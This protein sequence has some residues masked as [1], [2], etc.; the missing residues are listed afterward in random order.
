M[1]EMMN[2][3]TI[4]E[5]RT[6]I[7]PRKFVEL[8]GEEAIHQQKIR[9]AYNKSVDGIIET[10]RLMAIAKKE[11]DQAAW[12]RLQSSLP[13]TLQTIR[14]MVQIGES[15]RFQNAPMGALLPPSWRTLYEIMQLP[16]EIYLK[17]IENGVIHPEMQRR[18]VETLKTKK[19]SGQYKEKVESIIN[20]SH[21]DGKLDMDAC[22]G[23][24]NVEY[25]V[26][27]TMDSPQN[28]YIVED[29]ILQSGDDKNDIDYKW[30]ANGCNGEDKTIHER[31]DIRIPGTGL[32]TLDLQ[33]DEAEL[34]LDL[35]Y[36]VKYNEDLL[37]SAITDVGEKK[38]IKTAHARAII[39][40]ILK[41]LEQAMEGM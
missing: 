22:D 5:G 26:I 19:T 11:L 21:M 15:D 35:F 14:K 40:D 3:T 24:E 25:D 31:E 27:G 41:R 20:Y 38:Y 16:D 36:S 4:D 17:A 30:T 39:S 34:L 23:Q 29:S 6:N 10:C 32:M 18:D 12:K 33:K 28:H 7:I 37:R 1:E 8:N 2:K 13:F 9:T